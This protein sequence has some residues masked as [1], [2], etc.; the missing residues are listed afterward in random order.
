MMKRFMTLYSGEFGALLAGMKKIL[1]ILIKKKLINAKLF[2]FRKK[3]IS[4]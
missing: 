2:N 1:K 4:T 3:I